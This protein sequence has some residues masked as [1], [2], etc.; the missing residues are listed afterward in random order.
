MKYYTDGFCRASNPSPYGG[1]YTIV[2]ENNNLIRHEEVEKVGFT[3]NEGEILGILGAAKLAKEGDQISTDSM[4]CLGWANAG[5]SKA[6]PDLN[7]IFQEC[8]RLIADK[9]LNLMWERRDFNLAGIYNENK[10]SE[11]QKKFGKKH[12]LN[13][14]TVISEKGIL[15]LIDEVEQKDL[16]IKNL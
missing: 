13:D 16:F 5:K 15:S 2:D 6:R 8:K 10:S 12:K 14:T 7:H 11:R 9:K 1:G 3:N 4:C